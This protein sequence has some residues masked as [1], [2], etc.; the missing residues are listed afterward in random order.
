MNKR[1]F[2]IRTAILICMFACLFSSCSY[3]G[4][5]TQILGQNSKDLPKYDVDEQHFRKY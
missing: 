4:G 2:E 3:T 1:L 5:K